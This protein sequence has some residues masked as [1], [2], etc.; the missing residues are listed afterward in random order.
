MFRKNK[1]A[2]LGVHQ[3]VCDFSVMLS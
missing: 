2:T 1:K 3:Y